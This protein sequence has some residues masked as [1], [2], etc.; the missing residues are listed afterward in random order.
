[1]LPYLL[2][3][4]RLVQKA[5]TPELEQLVIDKVNE[6][7][8][9]TPQE[10]IPVLSEIDNKC[11]P[12][13]NKNMF[14]KIPCDKTLYFP[15]LIFNF[16][17]CEFESCER[18]IVFLDRVYYLWD[19]PNSLLEYMTSVSC[20]RLDKHKIDA[21]SLFFL[22][23][24]NIHKYNIEDVFAVLN[25]EKDKDDSSIIRGS[26]ERRFFPQNT[27]SVFPYIEKHL[28]NISG[29]QIDRDKREELLK[30]IE[31]NNFL[32]PKVV[33][34]YFPFWEE[35]ESEKYVYSVIKTD[36][37]CEG[38]TF[39]DV[40]FSREKHERLQSIELLGVPE[41]CSKCGDDN[42]SFVSLSSNKKAA[43]WKCKF[44]NSS[45]LLRA[46]RPRQ[47]ENSDGSE[48]Q[49]IPKDVQREVWRRDQ[50]RCVEC[51]S[52]ELLEFDH[53]I[54]VSKGGA[55]TVRNLQLLCESCNRR[56]SGKA[57]GHH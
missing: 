54:A 10:L 22:L 33:L 40:T 51:G 8:Y 9:V 47:T 15:G 50:G 25:P 52:Q 49:P 38:E 30:K 35:I 41:P 29:Q 57:P 32:P 45:L 44:C 26:E 18:P 7:E 20:K 4:L 56:K 2:E 37:K 31:E 55:N 39:I 1:M 46:D 13:V 53:I 23:W 14:D 21:A 24:Y 28:E 3:H 36:I 12:Q 27:K 48:R 34:S 43:R 5:V 42:W 6:N 11:R 17:T 19:N 16:F